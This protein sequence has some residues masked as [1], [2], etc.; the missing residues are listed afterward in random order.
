MRRARYSPVLSEWDKENWG[1]EDR[2]CTDRPSW[3]YAIYPGEHNQEG[4]D[5]DSD[6]SE[7]DN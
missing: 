2:D 4:I 6:E 1:K 5:E 3:Y 7:L